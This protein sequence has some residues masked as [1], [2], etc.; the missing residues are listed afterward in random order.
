MGKDG[1]SWLKFS[2]IYQ[3][4]IACQKTKINTEIDCKRFSLFAT[5]YAR[6]CRDIFVWIRDVMIHIKY[7]SIILKTFLT[8]INDF[9]DGLIDVPVWKNELSISVSFPYSEFLFCSFPFVYMHHN[10][11]SLKLQQIYLCTSYVMHYKYKIHYTQVVSVWKSMLL[12]PEAINLWTVIKICLINE[13]VIWNNIFFYVKR[14]Y[15]NTLKQITASTAIW[16]RDKVY[17][18][19]HCTD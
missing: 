13:L 6:I 8:K 10:L 17:C 15:E 4:L 11:F 18:F 3:I 12:I 1:R 7:K 9:T 19:Q 5:Y 16:Q 2:T 14:K